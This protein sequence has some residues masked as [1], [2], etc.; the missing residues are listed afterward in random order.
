M[1]WTIKQ[2]NNKCVAD[3]SAAPAPAPCVPRTRA[4]SATPPAPPPAGVRK[5]SLQLGGE[6]GTVA[7]RQDIF[8]R[9]STS[10]VK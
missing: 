1:T 10:S 3:P 8:N 2:I 5:T 6:L 7:A 9:I 4:S